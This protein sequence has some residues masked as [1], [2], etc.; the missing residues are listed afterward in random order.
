MLQF[1]VKSIGFTNLNN[2]NHRWI[3]CIGGRRYDVYCSLF[4]IAILSLSSLRTLPWANQSWKGIVQMR[5]A[6]KRQLQ[7]YFCFLLL[8]TLDNLGLIFNLLRSNKKMEVVIKTQKGQIEGKTTWWEGER[9][10]SSTSNLGSA[11]GAKRR[12]SLRNYLS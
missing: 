11:T 10:W 5:I 12:E 8:I 6:N 9:L 3:N 4:L 2:W 7:S 1:I